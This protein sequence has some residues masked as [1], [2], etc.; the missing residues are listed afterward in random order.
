MCQI[1]RLFYLFFALPSLP[2]VEVCFCVS[3]SVCSSSL[4]SNCRHGIKLCPAVDCSVEKV[5]LA[6]GE[7]VG[8]DSVRSAS[9]INSAVVIFLDS[10]DKANQLL[11]EWSCDSG[12]FHICDVPG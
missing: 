8:Y 3:S 11:G 5:S 1:V 4:V 9:R 2:I 10:I 12:L 7:V 6:V